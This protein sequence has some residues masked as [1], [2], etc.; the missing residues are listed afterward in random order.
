MSHRKSFQKGSVSL[1]NGV[2]TLRYRELDHYTGTWTNKREIIGKFKTEKEAR[3]FAAPIMSRVNTHNNSTPEQL[4]AAITFREFYERHWKAY[5]ADNHHSPNT[6]DQ[7]NS[8]FKAHLLPAFGDKPMRQITAENISVFLS[9]LRES[10]YKPGTL[11]IVYQ[12]LRVFFEIAYQFEVVERSPVRP[13]RHSP[14]A[15]KPE[16]LALQPE[17]IAQIFSAIRSE[18]ERLA[19]LLLAVTGMRVNE[20]LALRW[21]DFEQGGIL[22]I[23]HSLYKRE[24]KSLKTDGSRARMQLPALVCEMLIRHR[25]QSRF[26]AV[27]D[28]IF[29]RAD[30]TP[31]Q[32][33]TFLNHWR[34]ALAECGIERE[35]NKHGF[36]L[37]RHSAATILDSLLSD[38]KAVQGFL[39]H[40]AP[41]TTKIYVHKEQP[42]IEGSGLI[43]AEIF[44]NKTLS[45]PAKVKARG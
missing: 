32:Y 3:N 33:H 24:L 16:K 15:K 37:L 7:R 42:V 41:Q 39:R 27:T 38:E 20:C 22:S 45:V 34:D 1:R 28:F 40:T 35:S 2:Y 11:Q 21:Q 10:G 8:V 18:Q 13:K 5:E 29:C 19:V 43:L 9:G 25:E 12:V 23:N 36:H 31:M 44:P 26:K 30:G 6:V 14:K 4:H 17:T